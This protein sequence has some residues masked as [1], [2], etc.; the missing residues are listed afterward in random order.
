M[1]VTLIIVGILVLLAAPLLAL[2]FYGMSEIRQL[3]IREVDLQKVA[4]GTYTG[5]YR[6][7]TRA[8]GP[9]TWR[10]SC[11]TIASSP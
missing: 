4:G 9:S 3:V 2:M 1:K 10:W 5:S 7:T 8:A 6:L 11:T